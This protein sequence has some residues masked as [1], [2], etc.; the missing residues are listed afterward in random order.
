ME[1]FDDILNV[2]AYLFSKSS[3]TA[4]ASAVLADKIAGLETSFQGMNTQA[5]SMLSDADALLAKAYQLAEQAHVDTSGACEGTDTA[6]EDL[7]EP[8]TVTPSAQIRIPI[9]LDFDYRS[10]FERLVKE[11]HEA[12]FTDTHPEDLLTPEEME[13]AERFSDEL[14]AEFQHRTKL[15]A[16]DLKVLFIAVAARVLVHALSGKILSICR[17]NKGQEQ[18]QAQPEAQ[19]FAPKA[20]TVSQQSQLNAASSVDAVQGV[21]I[22]GMLGDQIKNIDVMKAGRTVANKVIEQFSTPAKILDHATILEQNAPF[23]VQETDYFGRED[24]AAYHR[25]LGWVIGT[26]NI[27]TDTI[28]TYGMKSY[29]ITRPEVQLGKPCVNQEIS[30]V[31]SVINPVLQKAGSYKNSIVAAA[32]QEALTQGLGKAD[33]EKV[34]TLFG[35]AVALE[36]RTAY[37]AENSRNMLGKFY[38]EWTTYAGG[39]AGMVLINTIVSA[40]HAIVYEESDGELDAYSIRTNKIIL[41]SSAMATVINSLPAIAGKDLTRLDFS[42]ILMTCMSLFQS[43]KFWI[44]AKTAFLASEHKQILDREMEKLDKYFAV[45]A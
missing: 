42:G 32:V 30:T 33:P 11:A 7:P 2:Y 45:Q 10:E 24:I 43:G 18:A 37:L 5:D 44:E 21:D 9:P 26:V 39:I 40:V 16:K 19:V 17:Q 14:D 34:R 31:F 22:S 15:H 13:Q 25:Y 1:Y 3:Q 4:K 6:Q 8:V 28:T 35:R 20:D 36:N 29:S 27:L 38:A 12:G 41:Y 23:D